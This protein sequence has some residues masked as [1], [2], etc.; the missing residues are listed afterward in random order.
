MGRARF[1][2]CRAIVNTFADEPIESVD[3]QATPRDARRENDRL[4]PH[5][6][7]AIEMNF[8]RSRI[9]A[10]DRARDQNFR[11]EAL[12]LLQ[13]A[14]RELVARNAAGEAE[15][16]LDAR[17]RSGLTTWSLALHDD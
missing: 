12:C 11:P 3:R 8:T 9:D 13:R 10:S 17:R 4:R 14:A 15:I 6:V 2:A 16:V 1:A 5:D 7:V